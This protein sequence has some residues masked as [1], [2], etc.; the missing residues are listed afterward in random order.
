MTKPSYRRGIEGAKTGAEENLGKSR[1]DHRW[2]APVLVELRK[3]F[4]QKLAAELALIANRSTRVCEDWIA[5]PPRG[6]PDG[7][8]L[9]ALLNSR[10]GDVVWKALTRSC[11]EPWRKKLNRQMEISQLLDQQ[12]ETAARLA[13]LQNGGDL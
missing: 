7:E 6:A 9:N 2:F 12:R 5:T 4:K 1:R 3:V 8:A 11:A 10:I 13:A